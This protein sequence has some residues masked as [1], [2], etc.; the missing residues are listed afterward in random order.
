MCEGED[1]WDLRRCVI[2]GLNVVAASTSS[3]SPTAVS[4]SGLSKR[5]F[6]LAGDKR[7]PQPPKECMFFRLASSNSISSPVLASTT[8]ARVL[9]SGLRTVTTRALP[10]RPFLNVVDTTSLMPSLTGLN[11]VCP[12]EELERPRFLVVAAPASF[13]L[14]TEL[15][16][17]STLT[18]TTFS[19][20][21]GTSDGRGVLSLF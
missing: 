13:S 11:L 15:L 10:R 14:V 8:G 9:D 1:V 3:S 20:D 2:L 19:F 7:L 16:D 21:W 6:V 18:P 17:A 5:E 4:S 12:R